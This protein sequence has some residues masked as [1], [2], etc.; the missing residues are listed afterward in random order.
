MNESSF[1]PASSSFELFRC[2]SAASRLISLRS[3][4][5]LAFDM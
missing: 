1:F 4:A 2:I 5:D 3:A